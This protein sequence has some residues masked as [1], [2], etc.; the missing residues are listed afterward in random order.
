LSTAVGVY[1]PPA[2]ENGNISFNYVVRNSCRIQDVGQVVIDVNQDPL[3][4]PFATAIGRNDST[5]IPVSALASDLEPLRIVA[6]EGAPAW[7]TIVDEQRAV[8]VDPAG[9]SGRLD[10]VA[11]VADPGGL[12]ARVPMSIQLINLAPLAQPDAVAIADV[13]VTFAPLANDADPDGDAITLAAVPATLTFANG[14]V[15]T[16]ERLADDRLRID[17]VAGLGVA[18]FTYTVVDA[19]GLVSAPVTV[20]VTVNRS[21]IAPDVDISVP[22]GGSVK[23]AIP[24]SDAEGG[25]LVL[26]VLDDVSPLT[27]GINGLMVTLTAPSDSVGTMISARYRVIDPLGASAVGMLNISVVEPPPTTTTTTTTV[28]PTTTG[29]PTTTSTTSSTSTT[30]PT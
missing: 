30:N 9:R 10:L 13:P 18:T 17:P 20:T 25:P 11:V 24:A 8:F 4:S 7:V 19:L 26:L 21:P 23:V 14:K 2:G 15:G 27:V 3:G 12:Q 28:P 1:T 29:P 5:T 6:I 16:I 22:A